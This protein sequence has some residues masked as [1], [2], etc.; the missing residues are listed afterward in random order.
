[1]EDMEE[2]Q[3]VDLKSWGEVNQQELSTDPDRGEQEYL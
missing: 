2:T 3:K 1:M